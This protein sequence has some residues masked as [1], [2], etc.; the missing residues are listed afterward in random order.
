MSKTGH[1]PGDC[2]G[3]V[4]ASDI[5]LSADV[6]APSFIAKSLMSDSLALLSGGIRRHLKHVGVENRSSL[7]ATG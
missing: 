4:P 6:D 3:P 5:A 1:G 2:L 7:L